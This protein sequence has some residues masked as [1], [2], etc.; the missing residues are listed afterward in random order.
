MPSKAR[1]QYYAASRPRGPCRSAALHSGNRQ[2]QVDHR[3]LRGSTRVVQAPFLV[4][5]VIMGVVM[6]YSAATGLLNRTRLSL[7]RDT[8]TIEHGPLPWPGRDSSG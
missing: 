1:Q 6:T 5:N 3:D 2:R 7:N 4:L 8:L